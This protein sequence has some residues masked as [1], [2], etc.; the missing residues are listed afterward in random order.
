MFQSGRP[1]PGDSPMVTTGTW[2]LR[3]RQLPPHRGS[4]WAQAP[5]QAPGLRVFLGST[6]LP[7]KT[8]SGFRQVR[9]DQD[10]IEALVAWRI[11]VK[12]GSKVGVP[13]QGGGSTVAWFPCPATRDLS[14]GQMFALCPP[15]FALVGKTKAWR[16]PG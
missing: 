14:F 4:I 3:Q 6:P 7:V 16:D 10:H 13:G 2:H 15:R 8:T 9:P 5:H 12:G 11:P 1:K